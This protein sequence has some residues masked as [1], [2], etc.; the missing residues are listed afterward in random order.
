VADELDRGGDT[1]LDHPYANTFKALQVATAALGPDLAAA[2]FSLAV[3]PPDTWI[4]MAAVARYWGELRGSSPGQVHTDLRTLASRELLILDRDEIAFHDLQHS[5]LLLQAD[6]LVLLHAGLLACYQRLL[7]A[8]A[9]WWRL[10]AGEP[11]IWDHLLYHLLGA[12]DRAGVAGTLTDLAYLAMRIALAGPHAAE[13]DLEQASAVHPDDPRIGWLRR[14]LTQHPHL[15]AGLAEPADVAVILAGWLAGPPTGIDCHRL[16]PLLPS[17][18]LAPRWGF[19]AETAALYRVL[20]GHDGGVWA[21]AFSPDGRWLASAG[22]D[23]TVRLWDPAT[24]AEQAAL[25]GHDGGVLALAFSPDG[26]QLASAGRDGTVRLWDLK[27]AGALSFLRL[28]AKNVTL[29]WGQ[30]VIAVGKGGSVVL[31]DVVT[32]E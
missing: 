13:T 21:V 17:V 26:R 8:G 19:P 10:P 28:D 7:P 23:G 25:T 15:F 2:Y 11:Y 9:G 16:D 5:Y 12:G 20:S 29:A 3:Y 32:Q 22:W 6:D 4:P 27:A 1:F 18:Y 30:S 24:G 31:F 14:W